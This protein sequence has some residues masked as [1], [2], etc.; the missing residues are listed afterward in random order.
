MILFYKFI[1]NVSTVADIAIEK[2]KSRIRENR[3]REYLLDTRCKMLEKNI[4]DVEET[5]TCA[6]NL[7][8]VELDENPNSSEITVNILYH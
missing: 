3:E 1:Y 7:T 4:Q 2:L 5:L 8:P 6:K